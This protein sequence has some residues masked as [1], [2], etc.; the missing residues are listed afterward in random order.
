MSEFCSS[1]RRSAHNSQQRAR[2]GAF[3]EHRWAPAHPIGNGQHMERWSLRRIHATLS[4]P[5]SGA[6]AESSPFS[7][8]GWPAL[9]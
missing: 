6:L 4:P 7:T 3:A 1:C 2:P 5:T 8:P 9:V